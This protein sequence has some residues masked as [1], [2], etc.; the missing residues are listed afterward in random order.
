VDFYGLDPLLAG[1]AGPPLVSK[2][3][4]LRRFWRVVSGDISPAYELSKGTGNKLSRAGKA[5]EVRVDAVVG[6]L[7]RVRRGILAIAKGYPRNSGRCVD[8][9][10]I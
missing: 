8:T 3:F 7:Q 6:L 5:L 10:G 2:F 9:T 4:V 1:E